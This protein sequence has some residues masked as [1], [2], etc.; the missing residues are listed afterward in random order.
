LTFPCKFV[1]Y[2]IFIYYLILT[3]VCLLIVGVKDYCKA[4]S[5]SMAHTQQVRLLWKRDRF[6][7]ETST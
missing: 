6:V 1:K 4:W 3:S 2:T 7:A 5:H